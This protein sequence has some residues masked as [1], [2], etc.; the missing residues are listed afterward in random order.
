MRGIEAKLDG[1][2][3]RRLS[4]VRDS[5]ANLLLTRVDDVPRRCLVDR[6]RHVLAELLE[7][8]LEPRAELL[9]RELGIRTHGR[10]SEVRAE[11]DDTD[12]YLL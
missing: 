5:V 9:H 10:T 2:L 11:R 6:I 4:E 1:R 8:S 12:S 3:V 7:L